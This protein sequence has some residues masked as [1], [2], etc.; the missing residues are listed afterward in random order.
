MPM[1]C[2]AHEI[3]KEELTRVKND[4][5]EIYSLDRER[6]KVMSEIQSNITELNTKQEI[7]NKDIMALKDGQQ[8]LDTKVTQKSYEIL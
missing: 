1:Q 7:M 5:G 8:D 3:L 4:I 6:E 2:E